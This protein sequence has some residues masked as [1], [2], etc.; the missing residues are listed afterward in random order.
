MTV[1][2]HSSPSTCGKATHQALV[3]QGRT[4]TSTP[5][6]PPPVHQAAQQE[7][8]ARGQTCAEDTD[9]LKP[10]KRLSYMRVKLWHPE[11]TKGASANSFWT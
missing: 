9:H 4:R 1:L 8:A 7:V 6:T 5:P 11:V 2:Y 3:V 10:Q